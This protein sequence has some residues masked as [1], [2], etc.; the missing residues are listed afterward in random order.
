MIVYGYFGAWNDFR[1]P[2]Q[3]LYSVF[4][5]SLFIS[6]S[7]LAAKAFVSTKN[8]LKTTS[9]DAQSKTKKKIN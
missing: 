2:S 9:A 7:M 3:I 4:G 5:A 6:A 8:V 1:I